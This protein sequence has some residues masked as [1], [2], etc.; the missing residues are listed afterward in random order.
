MIPQKLTTTS[1]IAAVVIVTITLV[2]TIS[3]TQSTT[4]QSTPLGNNVYVFAEGVYPQATFKF[5]DVTV[6]YDFQAFTQTSNL[7]GS[8]GRSATPE[9][10]LQRIAGETPFIHQAADEAYQS[11][12]RI[13][14]LELPYEEFDVDIELV[15]GGK[16]IREFKYG[17]CQIS[18]YK[19]VTE[20][21]K[22]EGYTTGG[23][24][25]FAVM[26]TYT[27]SCMGLE[28]VANIF[29]EMEESKGGSPRYG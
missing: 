8:N 3:Q 21:D 5:K 24:T 12:G 22:E 6:T 18:N 10:T 26:E 7:I 23:K 16:T 20:Y 14:S 4:A 2:I 1:L 17:D 29:D 27:L 28:P 13:S 25:G 9:F 15:Q 19:V 11:G